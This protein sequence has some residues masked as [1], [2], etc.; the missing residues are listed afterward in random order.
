MWGIGHFQEKVR[1][2]TVLSASSLSERARRYRELERAARQEAEQ[3]VGS[4][5][6]GYLIVANGWQNLA[7]A[8]E[9][10]TV[11]RAADVE[12]NGDDKG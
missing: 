6:D 5:R 2:L 10:A 8:A 11:V 4:L 7:E 1:F 3:F 12:Q 9:A